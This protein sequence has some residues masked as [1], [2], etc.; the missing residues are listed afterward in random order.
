MGQ[1]IALVDKTP[2]L[3]RDRR[4]GTTEILGVPVRL[5]DTAGWEDVETIDDTK[6]LKRSI[7][8]K[9]MGDMINQTRQALVYSDLAIFMLN[10]REGILPNDIALYKWL[11]EKKA[12]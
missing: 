8:R 11:V 1:K 6:E 7:N 12:A 10:T 2:G 5:V 4:E 9:M 3:T